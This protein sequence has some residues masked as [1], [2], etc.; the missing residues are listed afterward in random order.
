MLMAAQSKPPVAGASI[1]NLDAEAALLG[2]LLIENRAYDDVE[3]IVRPEDFADPLHQRIFEAIGQEIA[4]GRRASPVTLAPRFADDPGIATFG[5]PSYLASLT[6]SG[7][8]LFGFRDF[9]SQIADLAARRRLTGT[10]G[11]IIEDASVTSEDGYRSLAEIVDEADAAIV[12]AVERRETITHD[13]IG[14]SIDR[15]IARME[16]IRANAGSVGARTGIDELDELLGGFEPGQVVIVAGRPGMGKT[17]V[18]CS[19]ALGLARNGHGVGI[20]SLEM[21]SEELGMRMVADLCCWRRGQWIP[22]DVIRDGTATEEE[23]GLMRRAR[24]HVAK[25]PLDVIDFPSATVARLA[26]SIRRTKRKMAARGQKLEVAIVDYLQLLHPDTP[27][28]SAYEAV[29]QISR[30]LKAMAK[31]LGV[32]IVA[33]A[34]LS[35]AV[36]QRDD[37]RPQL[38]DLR[39]SGQIE[40][41]ADAVVF[42]YRDEYYLEREKPK[43]GQE[44]DHQARLDAARGQITF[45]CAKRR[46]GPTGTANAVYLPIYQAVRSASWR[47][48]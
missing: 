27:T 16:E 10:L 19:A 32:T 48:G 39:D 15:A 14:Q 40:Q 30:A 4:A 12:A 38:S 34:Q 45:I 6:G 37:K 22:F 25:W 33:L 21:R 7:A 47:V 36:E 18:A 11:R 31:E 42:L 46:N 24:E 13:T 23:F 35:R 8:A 41:D 3:S 29:S 28:K 5:G 1:Y 17:A 20:F 43:K 44:D 26:I 9:A 2:A